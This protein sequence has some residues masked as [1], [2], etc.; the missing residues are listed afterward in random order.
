[1]A[2]PGLSSASKSNR[3]PRC[4]TPLRPTG[5][6]GTPATLWSRPSR[7]VID[8]PGRLLANEFPGVQPRLELE[9]DQVLHGG[10]GMGGSRS[11][12]NSR[13]ALYPRTGRDRLRRRHRLAFEGVV[14]L[15]HTQPVGVIDSG[16]RLRRCCTTSMRFVSESGP[17]DTTAGDDVLARRVCA[18]ADL[19]GRAPGSGPGRHAN[20]REVGAER[21]P[22]LPAPCAL[23]CPAGTRRHAVHCKCCSGA[24]T[25]TGRASSRERAAAIDR[26]TA[27]VSETERGQAVRG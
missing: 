17:V 13:R 25:P 19:G 20:A 16:D 6:T 3:L 18:R 4:R 21:R 9:T 2:G 26:V 23:E 10:Y 11:S 8:A 5:T 27:A 1:M 24:G 15:A 12:R 7:R 14:E 22:Y